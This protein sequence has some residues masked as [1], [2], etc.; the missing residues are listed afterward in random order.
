MSKTI[1]ASGRVVESYD[2]VDRGYGGV[3]DFFE[4]YVEEG[5]LIL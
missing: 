5:K 2:I 4:L 3:A 1:E